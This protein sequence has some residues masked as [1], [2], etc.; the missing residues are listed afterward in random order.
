MAYY[1]CGCASPEGGRLYI[2][3][4]ESGAV[5]GGIGRPGPAAGEFLSAHSIGLDSKG[6]VYVGESPMGRRTQRFVK[7]G[8]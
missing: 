3:D 6:N 1:G 4:R 2:V 5:V 7:V 8:G